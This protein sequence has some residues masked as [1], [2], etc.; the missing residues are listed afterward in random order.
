MENQHFL[1]SLAERLRSTATVEAVYGQPIHAEGRTVVPVARVAYG[2]GGGV[3]EGK[4]LGPEKPRGGSGMG[5]GGGVRAVPAGV[6]ELTPAGTRFIP[7]GLARKLLAA[8]VLGL[9]LGFM[10]GRGT[11]NR[12]PTAR[13]LLGML[14]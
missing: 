5:G 8:G 3:G 11:L 4:D 7:L 9:S 1:E 2:F 13:R 10:L 14:R 12:R 6:V